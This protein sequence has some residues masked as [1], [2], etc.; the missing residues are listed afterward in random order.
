MKQTIA[1]QIL[2][3]TVAFTVNAWSDRARADEDETRLLSMGV[4]HAFED[5]YGIGIR[6]VH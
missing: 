5:A 6:P 4:H 3:L 1:R 2:V